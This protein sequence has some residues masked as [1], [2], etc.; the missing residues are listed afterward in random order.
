MLP[1]TKK[2]I[3]LLFSVFFAASVFCQHATDPVELV[4]NSPNK[5]R[6]WLVAGVHAALWSTSYI[7]LDQTWY[8]SYPR[9][10]FHFFN[11][12]AE[13]QQMDKFG[14]LWTCYNISRLSSEMW[15]WTG[16]SHSKSV[17]LG[18]I[19]GVA[20]QSIIEIQDGFSSEWGFSWGDMT[21]N[22][23]GAAAYVSQA[24]SWNEQRIQVKLGYWS[25]EYNTPE[26]RTRRDQL[27]GKGITEQVLKD[28]N[29][30][31]YWFSVNLR[32]FLP[33]SH[34][35]KWLNASAGYSADG[36]FGARENKWIDAQGNAH[37]RTE[38]PRIRRFFIAP[39]IDFTKIKTRS[40]FLRSVLFALN[41][42]KMPAPALELNSNGIF[43]LHAIYF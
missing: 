38:I 2:I 15:R 11:D 42:V 21:A 27:F 40:K 17:W 6:I 37:D 9:S 22:V 43:K 29:S 30:Q 7:I 3:F 19:S 5:K 23:L 20:Y 12:D 32:S 13:W 39:D 28:Y 8:A 4:K 26:L 16:L 14:H 36:M 35:P 10:S 34:L 31:T 1:P 33:N 25:N 24:L 18:G 41:M